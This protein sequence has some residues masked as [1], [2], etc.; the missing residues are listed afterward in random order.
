MINCVA[1]LCFSVVTTVYT[2]GEDIVYSERVVCFLSWDIEMKYVHF[3]KLFIEGTHVSRDVFTY[4]KRRVEWGAPELYFSIIIK[5]LG[6]SAS[7]FSTFS[8]MLSIFYCNLC[9]YIYVYLLKCKKIFTDF[10]PIPVQN[11]C[12]AQNS[13]ELLLA[14]ER[15]GYVTLIF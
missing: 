2:S 13:C 8:Q 14:R 10:F 6:I 4:L 7:G 5:P 9:S 12:V 11:V 3:S 1:L 15:P